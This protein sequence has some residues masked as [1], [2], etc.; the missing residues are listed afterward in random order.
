MARRR[1]SSGVLIY[2]IVRPE[3]LAKDVVSRYVTKARDPKTLE[4]WVTDYKQKIT[5]Y[6]GNT[7]R[8]ANAQSRL[9]AWYEIYLT[10]V[11]PKIKEIFGAAKAEHARRVI[12]PLATTPPV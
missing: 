2:G 9:A 5:A 7:A 6:V 1:R 8:Q 11:Y 3:D 10:E 12:K 4:A